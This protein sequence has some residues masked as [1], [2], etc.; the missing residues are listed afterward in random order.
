MSY[1][2]THE[3]CYS[4]LWRCFVLFQVLLAY[5]SSS[6]SITYPM[7]SSVYMNASDRYTSTPRRILFG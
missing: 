2:I 3:Y 4:S 1:E 7:S 6:T 5:F